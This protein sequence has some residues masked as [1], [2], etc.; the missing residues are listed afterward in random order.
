MSRFEGKNVVI[1]GGSG[2]IGKVTAKDFLQERGNVA[3]V[4]I[5]QEALNESREELKEF[6]KVITIVA[7]VTK[8]EDVKHYVQKPLMNFLVS[9]FSLTMLVLKAR[10]LLFMNKVLRTLL[11]SWM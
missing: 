8:E 11:K 10:L 3:L 1:T 5:S 2:G 9:T 6:G 7:D 4:D